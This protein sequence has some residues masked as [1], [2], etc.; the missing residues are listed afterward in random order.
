MPEH[1]LEPASR[2]LFALLDGLGIAGGYHVY[3][4]S[5]G[6]MLALEHAFDQP[7]GLKSLVLANT[8]A[9]TALWISEAQRLVADLPDDVRATLARHEE[10]GTTDSDEYTEAMLVFY[11]RHL[12]R[13]DPFPDDFMQTFGALQEDP[14]VYNA[15]WG[16]SE[17]TCTGSLGTWDVTAR[18]GEIDVPTLILSGR[19]DEATPAVVE[20]LHKGIAGSE[21]VVLEN[22]SHSSHVEEKE[23]THEL[24]SGFLDRVEGR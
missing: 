10:A 20:P 15:M 23:L 8:L 9:S 17:F 16:P 5:W 14:R 7:S 1:R 22:S 19:F 13:I 4:Q 3:G 11:A 2:E 18:L 21:W 12:C 6:G 24:L